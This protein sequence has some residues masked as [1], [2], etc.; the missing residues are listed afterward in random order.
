MHVVSCPEVRDLM[1]YILTLLLV[2]GLLAACGDSDNELKRQDL[3]IIQIQSVNN[4]NP[5]LSGGP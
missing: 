5:G 2:A 4:F 3:S 1:R